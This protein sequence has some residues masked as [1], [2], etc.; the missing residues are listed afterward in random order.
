MWRWRGFLRH[1]QDRARFGGRLI[2][3]D[4]CRWLP[5][6][7]GYL[8]GITDCYV[9]VGTKTLLAGHDVANGPSSRSSNPG[10]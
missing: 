9:R 6:G 2:I 8:E 1:V 4:A 7:L 3:F 10:C 5:I